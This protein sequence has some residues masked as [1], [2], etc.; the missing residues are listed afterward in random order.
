[1]QGGCSGAP[2][3]GE[4]CQ[5][6]V[7]RALASQWV[8]SICSCTPSLHP[9]TPAEAGPQTRLLGGGAGSRKT[10]APA[11]QVSTH[12]LHTSVLLNY[13]AQLGLMWFPP[14]QLS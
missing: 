9:D 2:S 8:P 6:A 7:S 5:G 14:S 4:R 10:T 13:P 12:Q 1:M 3:P 11:E